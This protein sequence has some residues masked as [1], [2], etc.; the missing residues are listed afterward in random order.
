MQP[1]HDIETLVCQLHALA[2]VAA[3]W[4]LQRSTKKETSHEVSALL[5]CDQ[6]VNSA[7][8]LAVARGICIAIKIPHDYRK[9]RAHARLQNHACQNHFHVEH[10]GL[11]RLASSVSL[12]G[13]FSERFA[14]ALDIADLIIECIG[15]CQ[16]GQGQWKHD[17]IQTC[18]T[19]RSERRCN[20]CDA[21]AF[22]Q[23]KR[24]SMAFGWNSKV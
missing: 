24:M 15:H 21:S 11:P 8:G 12:R 10:L 3:P 1:H 20:A 9:A 19:T 7:Q 5:V 13:S 18:W 2:H 6:S 17:G 14:E 4:K 22:I 23:W 16:S